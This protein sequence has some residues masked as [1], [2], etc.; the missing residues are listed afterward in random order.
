MVP[1]LKGVQAGKETPR[2]GNSDCLG[3]FNRALQLPMVLL[4]L[5]NETIAFDC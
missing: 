5:P 2:A 1:Q 3:I 4:H